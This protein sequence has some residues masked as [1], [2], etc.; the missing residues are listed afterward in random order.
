[1]KPGAFPVTANSRFA[2]SNSTGRHGM[3]EWL[4]GE[5]PNGKWMT[6]LARETMETMNTFA[7]AK[8][9]LMNTEMLSPVY[10][11]LSGTKRDEA[12]VISRSY[13][14]T[15]ILTEIKSRKDPWFLLQTNYDP[16]TEPWWIDDRQTPGEKCMHKLGKNDV[17][18]QG[19]YNVL[20][21]SCNFNNLTTYTALMHTYTGEFETHLQNCKGV[22]W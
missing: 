4:T 15:D 17:G 7:E 3:L 13:E 21:S 6:W 10:Y 18:F 19:I 2:D 11:I 5:M 8:D 14:K 22:C 1:M 9:H 12:R 16:D 20:S